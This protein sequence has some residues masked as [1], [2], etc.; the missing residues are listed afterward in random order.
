MLKNAIERVL[1]LGGIFTDERLRETVARID[2]L[3]VLSAVFA[4]L[5]T[6]L[7]SPTASVRTISGILS[8]DV[9]MTA[10]VLKLVNSSFFGMPR[11]VA[12]VEQAITLLGLELVRGVVLSH[13]LFSCFDAA[14]FP[15]FNLNGLWEHSLSVAR[16]S[17]LLATLENGDRI[18][19]ENCFMAGLVHDMGKLILAATVPDDYGGALDICRSRGV[20]LWEA[21]MAVLGVSHAEIGAY[22]LGL[23]GFEEDIVWAVARHHEPERGVGTP[24]L[25]PLLVHAANALQH[26]LVVINSGYAPHP[27]HMDALA[28]LGLDGRVDGWREACR[29]LLEGGTGE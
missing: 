18:V 17:R 2:K 25:A 12:S 14:R 26:E 4:E 6:E 28:A 20:S 1:R 29:G 16:L 13:C 24:A 3:P 10:G 15:G 5:T 27:L 22:L 7:R 23:W 19:Q 8:R 11:R 9:G 21:E